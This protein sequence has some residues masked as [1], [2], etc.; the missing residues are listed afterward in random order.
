MVWRGSDDKKTVLSLQWN[1]LMT[2]IKAENQ[3]VSKMC[4]RRQS[5]GYN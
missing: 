1:G 4:F 3:P 5:Q 2:N